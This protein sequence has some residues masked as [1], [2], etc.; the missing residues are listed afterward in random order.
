[1]YCNFYKIRW[2]LIVSIIFMQSCATE[3]TT[4]GFYSSND[5]NKIA[6]ILPF[7]VSFVFKKIPKGETIKYYSDLEKA[8]S[9]A[10]QK[11]LYDRL[12]AN[13]AS[14]K[15]K[16]QDVEET[17]RLLEKNGIT[18]ENIQKYSNAE[19]ARLCD[20]DVILIGTANLTGN[21]FTLNSSSKAMKTSL[22]AAPLVIDFL[23]LQNTLPIVSILTIPVFIGAS[24]CAPSKSL[25]NVAIINK[26]DELLWR[27]KTYN[28]SFSNYKSFGE[29]V[30]KKVANKFPYKIN[31]K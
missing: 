14:C 3:Y 12:L 20:V 13:Q 11:R 7:E 16:I 15:I 31:K 2:L 5:N 25:I 19:L 10:L 17:N 4:P 27:Y 21:S 6:A 28:H 24:Y 29:N 9:Y 22:I 26:N 18:L 1:M 23:L 8:E 30:M